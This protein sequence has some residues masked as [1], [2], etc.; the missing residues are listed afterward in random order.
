MQK[1]TVTLPRALHDWAMRHPDGFS[2]LTRK[3]LQEARNTEHQGD[4]A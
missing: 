2:G 4:P 1:F 3:L